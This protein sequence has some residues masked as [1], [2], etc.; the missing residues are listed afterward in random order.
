MEVPRIWREMS[1][2]M[3]FSGGVKEVD[4]EG[5]RFFKYPG[6]EILL[7]GSLD[8]IYSR[9]ERSG[10]NCETINKILFDLFGYSAVATEA[11][12]SALE[13][14]YGSGELVG[15]EVGEKGGREK[16]FRVDRLPRKIAR[17]TLFSSGANN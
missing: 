6:G 15:V 17:K 13:I 3:N 14:A 11:P 12:V 7:S 2:N 4:K 8:D 5:L 16:E 10:F 9:F 1:T